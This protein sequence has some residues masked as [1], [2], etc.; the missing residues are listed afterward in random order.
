MS[1]PAI[2]LEI[3][4]LCDR[5]E[6]E[7]RE[8]KHPDIAVFANEIDEAR[9]PTA[10]FWL[11]RVELNL[12]QAAEDT[13]PDTLPGLGS[14]KGV[15]HKAP[16][17]RNEKR[18][19]F[20]VVPGYRLT[21]EL[22]R[23]GQ[24]GVYE[25]T[26]L[27]TGQTVAVKFIRG[28]QFQ[29]VKFEQTRIGDSFESETAIVSMLKHPN[30]IRLFD[31]GRCQGGAYLAMELVQGGNLAERGSQFN[32]Y[33]AA[34][35]I[36]QIAEAVFEAHS[37]KVLHL[38]IKPQ[39]ILFD[40]QTSQPRLVDFGLA[41]WEAIGR[42]AN[43]IAGTLG[44]MAPEQAKSGVLNEQTDVFG[45]GATLYYLLTGQRPIAG[46]T[47]HEILNNYDNPDITPPSTLN[48][49]VNS[50]IERICM[51]CLA[52]SPTDRYRSTHELIEDLNQ[53]KKRR[54]V[55]MSVQ[56]A[57]GFLITAGIGLVLNLVSATL[58]WLKAPEFFIWCSVF[59]IYIP[60]F[61]L[62]HRYPAVEVDPEANTQEAIWAIW[63]GKLVGEVLACIALR[64]L[65]QD[66]ETV[67][68]TAYPIFLAFSGMAVCCLGTILWERFYWMSTCFWLL[69]PIA[70][71]L[72][73]MDASLGP[74][75]YAT[76]VIGVAMYG[77]YL[78][79]VGKEIDSQAS[80]QVAQ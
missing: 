34:E 66:F 2:D 4:Q 70:A 68:A 12:K 75:V 72:T 30:S 50:A 62:F 25:A 63:I 19:G 52:E 74:I 58:I 80:L 53:L 78:K 26:Q 77:I 57:N 16:D 13:L 20:P 51:K 27:S 33:E 64:I 73:S 41:K 32:Q 35:L 49:N 42:E 71:M 1:I 23:G 18:H 8:G 65:I 3:D 47:K 36:R 37:N 48:P 21:A 59:S 44:Y 7:F 10:Y 79:R 61:I 9:R 29:S 28:R 40:E 56:K 39:N 45:L 38:D 31:G 5:F 54:G 60:L 55:Q 43:S 69:V 6:R 67:L 11:S 24:G 22:G 46:K 76:S 17:R 15:G 14:A